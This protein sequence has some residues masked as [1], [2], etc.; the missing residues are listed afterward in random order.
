MKEVAEHELKNLQ[1]QHRLTVAHLESMIRVT[2][3]VLEMVLVKSH[4]QPN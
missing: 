2:S 4:V 3:S 1:S